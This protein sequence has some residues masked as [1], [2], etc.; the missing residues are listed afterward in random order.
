MIVT[1]FGV[2]SIFLL[3]L[4]TAGIAGEGIDDAALR[5][6]RAFL[7]SPELGSRR[8]GAAGLPLASRYLAV[9]LRRMGYE[10]GGPDGSFFLPITAEFLRPGP[11]C[12][13]SLIRPT[14]STAL[15][16]GAGFAPMRFSGT[17]DAEGPLVILT[18]APALRDERLAGCVVLFAVCEEEEKTLVARAAE[19]AAAGAVAVLL[20]GDPRRKTRDRAI[21][22][23]GRMI[24]GEAR[25]RGAEI[26]F[27]LAGS[28]EWLPLPL[29]ELAEI[30]FGTVPGIPA[31]Y[32]ERIKPETTLGIPVSGVSRAAIGRV[33]SQTLAD[34]LEAAEAEGGMLRPES[35]SVRVRVS[36]ES[37]ERVLRN[38]MGKLPADHQA[39]GGGRTVVVVA[40][41]DTDG[42]QDASTACGLAVAGAIARG[43]RPSCATLVLF[44]VAGEG[45]ELGRGGLTAGT[46]PLDRIS[47]WVPIRT[48]GLD[49]RATCDDALLLYRRLAEDPDLS[50]TEDPAG[51]AGADRPAPPVAPENPEP[52]LQS[53]RLARLSRRLEDA[54]GLIEK[55]LQASPDDAGLL[56]ERGRIRLASG[57]LRGAEESAANLALLGGGTDGR[58]DLLRSEIALSRG[59]ELASGE[60]LERAIQAGLPEALILRAWRRDWFAL[61]G[62]Q[63]AARDLEAAIRRA[64]ESSAFGALARGMFAYM[65]AENAS[66]IDLLT[67]AIKL[68]PT[69]TLANYYRAQARLSDPTDIDG[70]IADCN[71]ALSL[72][73]DEPDLYFDR[74]MAYLLKREFEP[75]IRDFKEFARRAR[76]TPNTAN[77]VYNIACA[78]ALM[79]ESDQALIYLDRALA[80]GFT[81][82]DH[83]RTDPDLKSIREDPRFERILSS[84]E[85]E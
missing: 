61:G 18:G 56:L 69:L 77:A 34:A 14:S 57:D 39:G 20:V 7:D 51:G 38:V 47:G 8:A 52:T 76:N 9:E 59:D 50:S 63:F 55:A 85:S 37:S 3:T 12:L 49:L 27:R 33:L 79:G 64:P 62:A 29:S 21:L 60:A 28:N 82:F 25:D 71:R 30:R 45:R 40:R 73:L 36:F 16:P 5:A 32:G 75:S 4:V 54:S 24:E 2:A 58:G 78:K 15:P 17:G 13:V 43:P 22:T 1:R 31:E 80:A 65:N 81:A 70:A 68:D 83:A 26:D 74:G 10:G 19:A 48:A 84:T 67:K 6:H 11:S 44:Y 72:G 46:P 23:D 41:Y 66:A 35:V 53:A 42:A